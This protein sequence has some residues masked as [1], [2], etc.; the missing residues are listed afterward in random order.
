MRPACNTAARRLTK[1]RQQ[2]PRKL[3]FRINVSGAAALA[4]S[5]TIWKMI[6]ANTKSKKT[7]W[8]CLSI[9]ILLTTLIAA[10]RLRDIWYERQPLSV[11]LRDIFRESGFEVP[12]YVADISGSKGSVDFQGDYSACVS[13][14][15]R[16]GDVERFLKLPAK[17]W[18]NPAEFR[19]LGKE[20]S[21][22]DFKVPAGAIMI[23][24]QGGEYSC[25]YA[26]DKKTDRV[27][28]WR[29]SW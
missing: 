12:D 13:F 2:T 10:G 9:P 18:K 15:I 11:H 5:E 29:S 14:S 23:E 3:S 25:K 19:S 7:R 22:G 28:F 20:G 17:I 24:E 8:G 26:V 1:S 27:Y 4:H 16:P 6:E 21:C